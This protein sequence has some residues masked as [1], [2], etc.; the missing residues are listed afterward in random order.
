MKVIWYWPCLW[1]GM[2]TGSSS[3]IAQYENCME[4]QWESTRE[5]HN[6]IM[7]EATIFLWEDVPRRSKAGVLYGNEV[8]MYGVTAEAEVQIPLAAKPHLL[9]YMDLQMETLD[10]EHLRNDVDAY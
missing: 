7:K 4:A 6:W 9:E 3:N 8:Q 1:V 5:R 2:Q 10:E